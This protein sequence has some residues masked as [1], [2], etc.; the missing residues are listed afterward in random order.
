VPIE[1]LEQVRDTLT[2]LL[3][4]TMVAQETRVPEAIAS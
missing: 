1:T 2:H 3:R 4:A